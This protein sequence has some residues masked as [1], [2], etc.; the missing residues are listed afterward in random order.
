M[1]R[2]P[3]GITPQPRDDEDFTVPQVNGPADGASSWEDNPYRRR[4]SGGWEGA[5]ADTGLPAIVALAVLVG[6]VALVLGVLGG[7]FLKGPRARRKAWIMAA[8]AVPSAVGFYLL[9]MLGK[10]G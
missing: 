6:P 8:V 2:P 9:T 7:L 10:K 3:D 5:F 4:G 1:S